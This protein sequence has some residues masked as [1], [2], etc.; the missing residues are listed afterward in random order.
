MEVPSANFPPAARPAG[1]AGHG[2][3][4]RRGMFITRK[5]LHSV[6]LYCLGGVDPSPHRS[7][8]SLGSVRAGHEPHP[9]P[10][11]ECLHTDT[12]RRQRSHPTKR[13]FRFLYPRRTLRSPIVVHIH[14]RSPRP[15]LPLQFVHL[16]HNAAVIE[17]GRIA[18]THPRHHLRHACCTSE[19]R[20]RRCFRR[21]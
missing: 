20:P 10:A 16:A 2:L 15:V 19:D 17:A 8:R 13:R 12:L 14:S 1:C 3:D 21:S 18:V 4:G 7:H 9:P 6:V 5:S 11:E